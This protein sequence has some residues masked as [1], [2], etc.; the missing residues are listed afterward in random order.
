MPANPRPRRLGEMDIESLHRRIAELEQELLSRKHEAEA[1]R[2]P[3]SSML[4]VLDSMGHGVIITDRH[5]RPTRINPAGARILGIDATQADGAD[6]WFSGAYLPDGCSPYPAGQRPVARALQGE[7]VNSEEILFLHPATWEAIWVQVSASPLVDLDGIGRGAIVVFRDV[8]PQKRALAALRETQQRFQS[9]L[10]HTPSI[11]YLKDSSGRYLFV[12]RAFED[13]LGR[14]NEEVIG[15]TDNE[16]FDPPTAEQLR[17]NDR[18][19]LRSGQSYQF[20]ET[21]PVN[22]AQKIFLSVKFPL[23]D[24]RQP[25]YA[26]CGIS[27]DINERKQSE[28]RL[29]AEQ[30]FLKQL[31]RAHEHD[32]QLMAYEI[33][34]GV[35]QYISAGLMHLESLAAEKS[36]SPKE[37]AALELAIDLARRSVAEGRRVMSGLRPPIL[38]EEGIVLAISYLAAEQSSPGELEVE[39]RHDVSF[40][41]LDSLLEGTLFRIA[42][43]ALTNVRRHSQARRAEVLLV[44]RGARIHLQICDSGIG[45][46]PARVPDDRF[47]LKGILKRAELF[48]GVARITSQ[49]GEGT[50]VSVEVPNTQ[51]ATTSSPAAIRR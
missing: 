47:G 6:D 1:V 44:E 7:S 49:P 20:E 10:E 51:V 37:Q 31:I 2:E 5:G 36:L 19:V 26:L 39:F 27:T 40:D 28:E 35:V 17:H 12:N 41:R 18:R 21:V 46:D 50:T 8:T 34:D 16:I 11:I 22:G 38:D 9:I 14:R 32:R 13:N 15:L 42:Q 43:E 29:R 33:H 25:P 30:T 24:V 4:S 48:G 3:L 23:P 45:F